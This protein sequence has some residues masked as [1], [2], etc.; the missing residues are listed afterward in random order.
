MVMLATSWIVLLVALNAPA[1]NGQSVQT[2]P[3]KSGFVGDTVELRCVFINGKP[4]VKISQVTWQKLINGTKQNV[5]TANPALGV[6]VLPPFK[7]RVSFKHPA[8]RQRTPSSLEDTTIVFNN[9]RLSDE[10]AYI[11]EYTTFPAGNRENMVN[12]TVFARPVTKMNLTS[13]TIVA[14]TPKRKMPVATCMSANG[15]PPSVIKWD[16]TLKGE[17]TFQE[18]RNPNGT[19]TV[20]SNYIVLPSRETHRQK[21]TCIV[22]YRAERFTDSVILNVQ[23]EP[24]VKIEG[25]D[26]N[27]YLNRQDVKLTCNADANPAVTIYQWKLLNG[28]LPNNIEIKNNTLF[29]KGPVTYEF[30]GTYVCDATNSISTRSGLVEVN[31][32]EKPMPQGPP[33]GIFGILGVVVVAGLI[34]GVV[35]TI[36]M[37]YRRGQKPRTETDNDLIAVADSC[38]TKPEAP[39]TEAPEKPES[40]TRT[41]LPPAHKPAPP[42]PKKKSSD[43]KGGLTSDEIQ[44]VHLD[45]EDEIQK[46][47]LQPPYYDMAQSTAFTDKPNSGNEELPNPADYVSCHHPG[48]QEQFI[49][50]PPPFAYPPVTFLP[51]HPTNTTMYTFQPNAAPPAPRPPFT[52]PKEQSV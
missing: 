20:R 47:P 9:L 31:V 18:T 14:R 32:T 12:L 16:T 11:C 50:P 6:S 41:D 23:Y 15:K 10:A 52:F 35:A 36:C 4:P 51:Q 49:E 19:V 3:S 39:G 30:G 48:N 8:V 46:I 29:F 28:S 43:M 13:P 17:A 22:T 44:V 26:G 33:G 2:D 42:P 24:E 21:L 25:F 40:P 5:A 37:V 45:K 38:V 34:V 7:D 27:W 1:G